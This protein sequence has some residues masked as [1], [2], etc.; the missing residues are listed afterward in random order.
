MD[1]TILLNEILPHLFSIEN[2]TND[3]LQLSLDALYSIIS[4]QPKSF[5]RHL[6]LL[7]LF[8]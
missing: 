8:T 6:P 2:S 7:N 1:I 5:Y 4:A 3:E